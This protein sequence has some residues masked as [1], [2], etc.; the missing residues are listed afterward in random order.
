MTVPR[1][2]KK[3]PP[4]HLFVSVTGDYLRGRLVSLEG[5]TMTIEVRSELLELPVSQVAQVIWLHDRDWSETKNTPAIE[6]QAKAKISEQTNKLPFQVHTITNDGHGLTMRPLRI[7]DGA[8]Q[9]TSDLLGETSVAIKEL[10]QLIFGRDIAQQLV[11]M[12]SDPWKLSLAIYPR[13]Y[14]EEE[15]DAGGGAMQIDKSPLIGKLAPEFAL[16]VVGGKM[17]RL[18]EQHDRIRSWIK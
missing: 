4:T 15:A 3:D 8:L 5:E 6:G 18:S 1:S 10:G 13:V 9:G 16:P 17:F 12:R 14:R 2:M 7:V 11:A